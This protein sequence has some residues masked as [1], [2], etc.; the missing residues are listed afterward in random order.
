MPMPLGKKFSASMVGVALRWRS[1]VSWRPAHQ[2]QD[3]GQQAGQIVARAGADSCCFAY[4]VCQAEILCSGVRIVH[5]PCQGIG[6][7]IRTVPLDLPSA[8]FLPR[9]VHRSDSIENSGY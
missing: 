5:A 3:R 6:Q 1:L 2:Y 4:F 7:C 8:G 9:L